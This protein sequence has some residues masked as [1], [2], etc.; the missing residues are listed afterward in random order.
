[1]SQSRQAC[2]L[3]LPPAE[4][5]AGALET[6]SGFSPSVRSF[7]RSAVFFFFYPAVFLSQARCGIFR[8]SHERAKLSCSLEPCTAEREP[9]HYGKL[10]M[11]GLWGSS[12]DEGD[13]KRCL[14]KYIWCKL[15]FEAKQVHENQPAPKYPYL[16]RPLPVLQTVLPVLHAPLKKALG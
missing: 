15:N 13:A 9:S 3:N 2:G 4:Q 5:E 6:L 16:P 10:N 8:L 14:Q 12:S 1:M 7:G 11:E